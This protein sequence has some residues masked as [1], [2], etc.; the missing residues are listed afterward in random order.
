VY[1]L[2]SRSCASGFPT[3]AWRMRFQS[4]RMTG[5]VNFTSEERNFRGRECGLIDSGL[6]IFAR[7][8]SPTIA[9]LLAREVSIAPINSSPLLRLL[10]LMA[11]HF[12]CRFSFLL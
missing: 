4:S 1:V 8:S 5:E 3:T 12:R 7:N 9:D 11:M 10:P 6:R 2:K